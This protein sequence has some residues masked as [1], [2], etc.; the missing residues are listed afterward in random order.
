[1][2][3]LGRQ[4]LLAGWLAILSAFQRLEMS[5]RNRPP[6][7]AEIDLVSS[8]TPWT[9]IPQMAAWNDVGNGSIYKGMPAGRLTR[10]RQ[11]VL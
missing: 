10:A 7:F 2:G 3:S 8:H 1:M 11:I 4:I 5:K 6:L 9:R